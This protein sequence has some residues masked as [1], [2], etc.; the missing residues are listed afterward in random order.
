MSYILEAL[1]KSERERRLGQVPSLPALELDGPPKRPR[2]MLWLA[3]LSLLLLV[4]ASVLAFLW[5]QGR[6]ASQPVPVI[7]A[8]P[9]PTVPRM[10][11]SPQPQIEQKLMELEKRLAELNQATPTPAAAPPPTASPLPQ[12]TKAARVQTPRPKREQAATFDEESVE[13]PPRPAPRRKTAE[14]EEEFMEEELP[15]QIR[16]LKIN[17]VAYSEDPAERFAVINMSRHVPGDRL[18]GG[19]LLL[20]ILPNGLSLELNGSRYR[21]N[22]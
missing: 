18:P 9:T 2:W 15:K 14:P 5:L 3:L 6:G 7:A 17:V 4:N 1:K 19:V 21:I 10:Q 11:A 13:A 12:P 20:D 16:A 22:H 8:E